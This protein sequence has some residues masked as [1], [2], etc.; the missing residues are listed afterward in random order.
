MGGWSLGRDTAQRRA[1]Y[2]NLLTDLFQ[3]ERLQT[4]V[5]K[6]KAV[7]GQAEK[8]ITLAKHGQADRIVELANSSSRKKLAALVNA[9]RADQLLSLARAG[10]DD[11]LKKYAAQIALGARRQV[12]KTLT[13]K[14]TVDKLF[15]EIAPT[16]KEREGGYTRLLR[17]GPR[18]GDGAEM[19]IVELVGRES[20]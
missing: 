1:L 9:R 20:K 15:S 17:V 18:V 4:T 5:V 3:R 2:R 6:A 16:Y 19:A 8:M 11:G 12:L 10:D 7:R 14:K 13:D